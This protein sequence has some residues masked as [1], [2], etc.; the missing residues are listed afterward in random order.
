MSNNCLKLKKCNE[1]FSLVFQNET[2]DF[3]RMLKSQESLEV[4]GENLEVWVE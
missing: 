2:I 1:I 3:Q 4:Q